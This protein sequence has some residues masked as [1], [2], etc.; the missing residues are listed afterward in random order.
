MQMTPDQNPQVQ[1]PPVGRPQLRQWELTVTAVA[2]APANM[3]RVTFTAPDIAE[4]NYRAGQA[5]VMMLPTGDGEFGRRD[6]TIRSLDAEKGLLAVDFLMHGDD[7]HLTPGPAFARDAKI[8]DKINVRGPRGGATFREDADWH[9]IT[10]DECCLPAIFHILETMPAKAQM[11]VLVEVD[12]TDSEIALNDIREGLTATQITWLHRGDIKAGPSDFMAQAVA[13]YHLPH[14]RG[15]AI[16][17]GETSNVRKQRQN[18][19]SRGLTREQISSEG[20]WRPGRI[21][22]HDHVDD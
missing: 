11:H 16:L 4:F 6:Y 12:N 15:Q 7:A 5:I 13:G 2:D 18:L 14:G 17:I 22:G 19:L 10:G 3:R 1:V 20:Y 8:G 21:G 9:L